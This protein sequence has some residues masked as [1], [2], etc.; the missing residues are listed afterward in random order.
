M[1]A[2]GVPNFPDPWKGAVSYRSAASLLGS[3][4]Q[5]PAGVENG[6]LNL[7]RRES[8]VSD[9]HVRRSFDRW[10]VAAEP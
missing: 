10:S 8:E 5:V 7:V 2:H 1:R 3:T 9:D 4:E 6:A